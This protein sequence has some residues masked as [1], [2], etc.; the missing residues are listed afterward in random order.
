VFEFEHFAA[1]TKAIAEAVAANKGFSIAGGGETVTAINQ[2]N[3]TDAIS[4]ISTGG[5]AFLEYVQGDELPAVQ[6]LLQRGENNT[7]SL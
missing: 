5:G 1:G 7:V 4:Y 6:I 2:F 3:V